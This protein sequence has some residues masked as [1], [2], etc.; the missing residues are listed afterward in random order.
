[1]LVLGGNSQGRRIIILGLS[2]ENLDRLRAGKPIQLAGDALGFAGDIVIFGGET[3]RTMARE[4]VD[5]MPKVEG[6]GKN[7]G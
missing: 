4:I 6:E 7:G 1:M 2:H 5:L 3:E